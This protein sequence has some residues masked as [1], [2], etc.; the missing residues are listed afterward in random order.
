MF[1][2]FEWGI[3]G[4]EIFSNKKTKKI[5]IF[6]PSERIRLYQ[7]NPRVPGTAWVTLWEA[8]RH[9]CPAWAC[10][11]HQQKWSFFFQPVHLWIL[12]KPCLK[13]SSYDS[14]KKQE[15]RATHCDFRSPIKSH[16]I[17][18]YFLQIKSSLTHIIKVC[19]V[20]SVISF[21]NHRFQM[22]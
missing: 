18:C 2:W 22:V 11:S 16:R 17:L 6:H 13:T 21:L 5:Q 1:C 3:Y 7:I 20:Y 19:D 12:T 10:S 8:G 14:L 15:N 9:T 4:Y